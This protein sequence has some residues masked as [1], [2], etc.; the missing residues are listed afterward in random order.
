MEVLAQGF[1]ISL[2]QLV[3]GLDREHPTKTQKA[4]ERQPDRMESKLSSPRYQ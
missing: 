1:E 3:R 4:L 2:A